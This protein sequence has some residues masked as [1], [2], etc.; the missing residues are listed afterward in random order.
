MV[1]VPSSYKD[2]L[3]VLLVFVH[4]HQAVSEI[5]VHLSL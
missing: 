5:G 2:L 3:D 4:H 1:V